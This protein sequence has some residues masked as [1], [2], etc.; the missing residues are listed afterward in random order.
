MGKKALVVGGTG[1]LADV[2]RWLV[3]QEYHVAVVGRNRERFV[4]V[5]QGVS[6]PASVEYIQQDYHQTDE[7]RAAIEALLLH[8]GP[9]DLVVSW[10]HLTAPEALTMIQMALSRQ[11]Q[12]W[13]LL[14]V[15]GSGAWKKPP[16]VVPTAN[17]LYRRV[18][19]GFVLMEGDSARWLSHQEISEGVIDAI[20]SDQPLSI[21]GVVEPWEKRPTY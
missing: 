5:L 7:L 11:E 15:C 9:F 13:R 1:M 8:S 3:E 18:I 6:Q 20:R 2:V 19:L 12:E 16:Q 17:C 21:V 14:Q 4:R 10:I